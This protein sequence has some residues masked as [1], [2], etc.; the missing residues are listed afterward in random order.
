M[1]ADAANGVDAGAASEFIW[2]M[3]LLNDDM[4][5]SSG[6]IYPKGPFRAS[7]SIFYA[8]QFNSTLLSLSLW[9]Q[10]KTTV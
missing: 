4:M 7:I 9:N 1:E 3:R 6:Q 2:P 10:P 5:L 8:I